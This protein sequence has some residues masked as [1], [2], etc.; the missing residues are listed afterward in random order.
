MADSIAVL[1]FGLG[2]VAG[3]AIAVVRG[4]GWPSIMMLVASGVLLFISAWADMTFVFHIV[5]WHGAIWF[6]FGIVSRACEVWFGVSFLAF[7]IRSCR[8]RSLVI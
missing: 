2:L 7:V 5:S 3:S 1:L 8:G 6:P 4:A